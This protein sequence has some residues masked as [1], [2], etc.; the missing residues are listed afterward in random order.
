MV[1]ERARGLTDGMDVSVR[2]V[3]MY[4]HTAVRTH[5]HLYKLQELRV[6]H[7]VTLVQ[8]HD[9]AGDTNLLSHT[10]NIGARGKGGERARVRVGGVGVSK[11]IAK[12]SARPRCPGKEEHK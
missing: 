10:Y 7:H 1:W 11:R 3:Y 2:H 12:E 9:Q 8:E 4:R 6:V 5:L